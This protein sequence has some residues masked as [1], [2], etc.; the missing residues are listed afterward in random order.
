MLKL[1]QQR[2]KLVITTKGLQDRNNLLLDGRTVENKDKL[3]L[4]IVRVMKSTRLAKMEEGRSA[5]KILTS[6][7]TG[8]RPLGKSRRRCEENIR[9]DLKELGINTRNWIDSADVM[10][11]VTYFPT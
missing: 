9:M 5:F 7:P 11:T 6:K 10:V 4:T 1:L 8:K 3:I 2:Y